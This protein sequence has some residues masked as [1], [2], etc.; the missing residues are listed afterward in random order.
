[1]IVLDRETGLPVKAR[2]PEPQTDH[3]PQCW[4]CKRTLAA[5]LTRPWALK[6]QRCNA[7]NCRGDLAA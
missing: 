4:R 1:M 5:Y 6:C 7:E 2:P 3:A